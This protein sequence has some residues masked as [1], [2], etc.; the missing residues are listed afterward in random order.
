MESSVSYR[1]CLERECVH[2]APP[3]EVF[4]LLC[5]VREYEWIER[6][7]CTVV[8]SESGVAEEGCLFETDFAGRETW[9]VTRYESPS[10]IEFCIFVDAGFVE[11]LI[12]TVRPEGT[13]SSRVHWKRIYTALSA[14]GATAIRGHV[15]R[16]TPA[17]MKELDRELAHYL[18]TGTMLR[19][20]SADAV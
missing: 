19:H 13:S 7:D 4:P 14:D 1:V 5:P 8:H 10:R 2:A 6:W 16:V 3:G 17:R 9:V 11:R 20:E 12:I 18:A 15:E